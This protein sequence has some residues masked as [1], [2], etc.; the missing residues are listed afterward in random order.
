MQSHNDFN[1]QSIVILGAGREGLSTARYIREKYPEA[2]LT[3]ADQ[4]DSVD[5]VPEGVTVLC[6]KE[7]PTSLKEWNLVV[8]S[9]GIH[10]KEPLLTTANHITTATNI[11]FADC[12]GMTI[13][14]TGSKGK[15]TTSSLIHA[16]FKQAGLPVYLAGN[17]GIPMLDVLLDHNEPDDIFVLEISSYQA[18]TLEAGPDIAVVTTLFPEHLDYH[19]GK[20]QYY[21]DK[22]QIVMKQR[23]DQLAVYNASNDALRERMEFIS[24]KN[25]AYPA[26]EA[27]H[28]DDGVIMYGTERVM[29]T[30]DVQ[31]LGEHN[32]ENIL[33][34]VT[35]AKEFGITNEDIG[36]A[37]MHF[38]GLPHRLETV[39][40]WKGITF[41]NDSLST[42]P[43][44]TIAALQS[45]PNVHTLFLGGQ[46]RGYDFSKLAETIA[47]MQIPNIIFFPESGETIEKALTAA[48]YTPEHVL[49]TSSMEEAVQ[50]AYE[51]TQKGG[52]ALLS[53]A[54]PSYSIF[55]NYEDRGN[56][57][58]N[59]AKQ[60][61]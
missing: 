44:S 43:E 39:G 50:F 20:N 1:N 49:H 5:A 19:G 28:I 36:L 23:E 29:A 2:T 21:L 41:V 15:S 22:L 33:A 30:Q 16:I 37:V 45:V 38:S 8:A 58:S 47:Q 56:Q 31:L 7:Y 35:V 32:L 59:F 55:T 57:F 52:T 53:C 10:P 60:G 4:K 25:A 17:I 9:P 18:R 48:G 61:S 26:T 13:G 24:Q 3:I 51:H 42:T 14:V 54:S 12:A 11:F 27:A 46:D 6:G 34:A 40:T